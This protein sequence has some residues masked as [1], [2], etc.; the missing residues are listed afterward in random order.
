MARWVTWASILAK[1][2]SSKQGLNGGLAI[3]YKKVISNT[4]KLQK[5]GNDERGSVT[6]K[7][8]YMEDLLGESK[9]I[10]RQTV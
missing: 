5:E 10:S 6:I 9:N 4:Y 3:G 1:P 8:S 7:S 2:E